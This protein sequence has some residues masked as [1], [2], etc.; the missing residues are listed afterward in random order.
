MFIHPSLD[1]HLGCFHFLAI[2]NSAAVSICVQ[3]SVAT[4]FEYTPRS[5]IV[6]SYGNSVFN[7]LKNCQTVFH[8]DCTILHS[9]CQHKRALLSPHPH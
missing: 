5:G 8:S 4:P 3:G 7:L 9:H 2:M 1:G 6:G